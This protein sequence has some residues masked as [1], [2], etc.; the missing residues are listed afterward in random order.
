MRGSLGK[1]TVTTAS[2]D[3]A[4]SDEKSSLSSKPESDHF[5]LGT[6]IAATQAETTSKPTWGGRRSFADVLKK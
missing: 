1:I 5:A 6:T 3:D 2:T 4:S